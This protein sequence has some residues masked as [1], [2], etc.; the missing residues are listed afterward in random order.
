MGFHEGRRIVFKHIREY[1]YEEGDGEPARSIYDIPYVKRMMAYLGEMGLVE[2]ILALEA[3]DK[4][5]RPIPRK[6]WGTA[7]IRALE[8]EYG[9]PPYVFKNVK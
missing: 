1:L 7:V 2:D 6:D 5:M 4:R 8:E 9:F 3:F